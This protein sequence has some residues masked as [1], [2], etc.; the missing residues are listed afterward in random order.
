MFQAAKGTNKEKRSE[1]LT[2]HCITIQ[3]TEIY[4]LKPLSQ[5]YVGNYTVTYFEPDIKQLDQMMPGRN[6]GS[7][8]YFRF[9]L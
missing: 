5:Q 9:G 4:H 8:W 1:L 3:E 6:L 2:M 7:V